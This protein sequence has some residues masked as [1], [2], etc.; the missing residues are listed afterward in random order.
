MNPEN[1]T[2]SLLL[3]WPVLRLDEDLNWVK[4]QAAQEATP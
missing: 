4:S 2:I 3:E 1:H